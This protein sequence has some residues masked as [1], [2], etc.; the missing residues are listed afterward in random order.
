MISQKQPLLI[1]AAP[2]IV[3]AMSIVILPLFVR[4]TIASVIWIYAILAVAFNILLGYTGL[5]SFGQATFFGVGGYVA[6]LLLIHYKANLLLVL[7]AGTLAGGLAAALVGRISIQRLGLYFILLTF[8]FNQMFYFIAYQWS[9]LTGGE[10]GLPGVPRPAIKIGDFSILDLR[11]SLSYYLFVVVIF[12]FSMAIMKWIV[13]SPLGKILQAVRENEARAAAV[14]Y[15]VKRYKWIAFIIA[16]SFSGMAGVLY[17]MLFG[18][19][20]LDTIHWLTSGD[21]VFMA[22]IGGIGNFYG[23]IIGAAFYI[24]LSESMAVIWARWPLILGIAFILVVLFFRGGCVVAVERISTRCV[25][26]LKNRR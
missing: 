14:G 23:P 20:P 25:E 17:S 12:V 2:W 16:G 22:L 5:L 9:S 19:V 7:I 15:N 21:I 18:I 6:G 1:K 13:E 4:T 3:I 26:K 8:A 11:G 10:D 24:W